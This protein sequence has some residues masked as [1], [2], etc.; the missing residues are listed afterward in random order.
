MNNC[1]R[2]QY[3]NRQKGG[4]ESRILSQIGRWETNNVWLFASLFV[5]CSPMFTSC[6]LSAF[7]IR[8]QTIFSRDTLLAHLLRIWWEEE[9]FVSNLVIGKFSSCLLSAFSNYMSDH[10]HLMPRALLPVE[11]STQQSNGWSIGFGMWVVKDCRNQSMESRRC[12]RWI[13]CV[14]VGWVQFLS[15]ISKRALTEPSY[16]CPLTQLSTHLTKSQTSTSSA[17]LISV[18]CFDNWSHNCESFSLNT[19]WRES[20]SISHQSFGRGRKRMLLG[21]GAAREFGWASLSFSFYC[22]SCDGSWSWWCWVVN[23]AT[24]YQRQQHG[25]MWYGCVM[26]WG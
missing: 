11:E 3:I 4:S 10:L 20:R 8:C 19:S 9:E 18:V 13:G 21:G 12:R 15:F 17:C 7:P 22:G 16:C 14:V 2:G 24:W 25:K 6:S 1:C 5:I 26:P 23:A